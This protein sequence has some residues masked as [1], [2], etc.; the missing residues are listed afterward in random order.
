MPEPQLSVRSA[1]AR[2]SMKGSTWQ[3]NGIVSKNRRR[4]FERTVPAAVF[5]AIE[6]ACAQVL[7]VNA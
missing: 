2:S 1:R 7:S 6:Q 3:N 5:D 4:Q